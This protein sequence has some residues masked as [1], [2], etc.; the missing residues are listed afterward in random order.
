LESK[1]LCAQ[2][3]PKEESLNEQKRLSEPFPFPKNRSLFWEDYRR[4]GFEYVIGKI[5]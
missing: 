5:E 2:E 1:K 3:R 4:F